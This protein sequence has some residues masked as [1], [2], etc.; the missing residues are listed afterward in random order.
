MPKLYL[1]AI[2]GTGSRVVKSLTMLLA[3]GIK[4]NYEIVPIILD[5]DAAAADVA[6]T[7]RLLN[8]YRTINKY[9]HSTNDE[10]FFRNKI[11]SLGDVVGAATGEA[12]SNEFRLNIADL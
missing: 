3:S 7:T 8:N 4:S 1:F 10:S 12:I 6:R 5:P 2:G 11:E 9:V